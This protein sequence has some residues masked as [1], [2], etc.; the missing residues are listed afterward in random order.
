MCEKLEKMSWKANRCVEDREKMRG[1]VGK[2]VM[3]RSAI[4]LRDEDCSIIAE[5]IM[6]DTRG[7]NEFICME[8]RFLLVGKIY[9]I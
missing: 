3:E 5:N 1:N 8:I 7:A 4:Y 6:N 9:L 2:S